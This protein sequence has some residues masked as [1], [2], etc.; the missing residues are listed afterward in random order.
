M[1]EFGAANNEL[2]RQWEIANDTRTLRAARMH[3]PL[4]ATF[5]L[6][7]LCNLNC[8]MCFVRLDKSEADRI[9]RLLTAEEWL[10]LARETL[11]LG[12]LHLLLTGGEVLTRP[13]FAVLYKELAHMGFII[14]V[15][16]NATLVTPEIAELFSKYPP[17]AIDVTLYGASPETYAAVCGSADAFHKTLEGLERLAGL[18]SRLQVRVTFIK[19]NRHEYSAMHEIADRYTASFAINPFITQPIRGAARDVSK[20]RLEPTEIFEVEREGIEYYRQK[21]ARGE[22]VPKQTKPTR[23]Q[24]IG[25]D[26][27]ELERRLTE[28][29]NAIEPRN[30]RCTAAKSMYSIT[31]DGKMVPCL[32]FAS[33]FT[34]PLKEGVKSAWNRIPGL[35]MQIPACDECRKCEHAEY[36]QNCPGYLQAETGAF[37]RAA[38]YLC[39]IARMKKTVLP[40]NY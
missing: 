21:L 2:A 30:I 38:P 5:E 6:T 1:S 8:K 18:P 36:C 14:T 3:V 7:P 13:D 15:N 12:T 4:A 25:E 34:M 16:T 9:G 28:A 19:A 23:S 35:C 24:L 10:R 26:R 39:D 17:S 22:S 29:L 20:I 40:E 27:I 32:N 11:E 31:W 33:P 37:D